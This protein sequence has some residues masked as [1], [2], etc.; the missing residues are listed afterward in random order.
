MGMHG[1]APQEKSSLFRLV[2]SKKPQSTKPLLAL[3]SEMPF[4]FNL[5]VALFGFVFTK[6]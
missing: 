3:N 6:R 2:K 4:S 1:E 5:L